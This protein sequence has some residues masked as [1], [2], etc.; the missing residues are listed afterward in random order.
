MG[1]IPQQLAPKI[2]CKINTTK[3]DHTHTP[4]KNSLNKKESSLQLTPTYNLL[5]HGLEKKGH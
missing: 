2:Q 3:I 5:Y 1:S 4:T